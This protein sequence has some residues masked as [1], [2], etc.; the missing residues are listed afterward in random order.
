MTLRGFTGASS[1]HVSYTLKSTRVR[2]RLCR[3][4]EY[5]IC[6]C[7]AGDM[8]Q[9]VSRDVDLDEEREERDFRG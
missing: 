3:R 8:L 5:H 7:R 4:E 6:A 1:W 9:S 2:L